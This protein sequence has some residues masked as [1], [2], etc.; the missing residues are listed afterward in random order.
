MEMPWLERIFVNSPFFDYW[1]IKTMRVLKCV[2][3]TKGPV[4]EIG[5][6]KGTTTQ[7]IAR[8]LPRAQI[9]ATDYDTKQIKIAKKLIK[10]HPLCSKQITYK[11][12]D[13]TKLAYKTNTFTAAFSFLTIHHIAEWKK[14]IEEL[15][16]VLKP[17]G[18]LYIDDLACK[19]FPRLFHLSPCPAEGV[20]SAKDMRKELERAGFTVLK[21]GGRW[22]FLIVARK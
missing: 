7:E 10:K 2:T 22:K 3:Q 5:C 1:R 11:Q 12:A 20:F 17:G 4:L 9:I 6:G 18:K 21:T 15:Y 13:A 14:A 8:K 19:P 16:R